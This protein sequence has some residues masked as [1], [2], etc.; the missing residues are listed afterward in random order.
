MPASGGR[1]IMKTVRWML[2]V[3]GACAALT[4][5]LHDRRSAGAEEEMA[6]RLCQEAIHRQDA[7]YAS[8]REFI[9]AGHKQE[10]REDVA[11]RVSQDELA[12]VCRAVLKLPP[13]WETA[14]G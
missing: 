7:R 10:S 8:S 4:I 1:P 11:E 6:R 9:A 12:T 5:V 13:V 2:V 3:A 14:K